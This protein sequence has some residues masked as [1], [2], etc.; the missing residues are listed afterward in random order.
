MV[1]SEGTL[2][3]FTRIKLK[4]SRVQKHRVGAICHFARFYEA[5]DMTRYMVELG[6]TAVELVDRTMMELAR[7]IATFRSTLEKYVRGT[8]DVAPLTTHHRR[9]SPRTPRTPAV[10]TESTLM[11][12]KP[13]SPPAGRDMNVRWCWM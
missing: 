9:P 5:M 12:Q 8:P 7:Q 4:L 13:P 11:V 2:G 6:P 1:G 10:T 3:F